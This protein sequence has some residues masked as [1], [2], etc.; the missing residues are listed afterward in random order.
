MRAFLFFAFLSFF[1]HCLNMNNNFSLFNTV[2]V[3]FDRVLVQKTLNLLEEWIF[4]L[5]H[6]VQNLTRVQ[7]FLHLKH[8]AKIIKSS[9]R[10]QAEQGS[11][12]W[13]AICC[14]PNWQLITLHHLSITL[15]T[16]GGIII[17]SILGCVVDWVTN[18]GQSVSN[19]LFDYFSSVESVLW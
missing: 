4:C 16:T 5:R 11:W 15:I 8:W 19:V 17:N 12:H 1:C 13:I 3:I 18:S 14:C 7:K 6:G 2:F 10:Q 9:C